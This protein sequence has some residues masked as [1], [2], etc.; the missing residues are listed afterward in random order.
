[1]SRG[2]DVNRPSSLLDN[3]E[4]SDIFAIIGRRSVSLS[5]T[6][7]QVFHCLPNQNHWQKKIVGVACFTKDNQKKSY[8]IRIV[9]LSKRIIVWEQE[10]YN[11]FK[12]N[13][14]RP[15]FH[16]FEADDC[17]AGLNFADANEAQHFK[18]VIEEKLR[19]K[20][21]RKNDRRQTMARRGTSSANTQGNVLQPINNNVNQRASPSPTISPSSSSNDLKKKGGKVKKKTRLTKD[22]IGTPSD[23]RHVGHVG[24]DPKGGFDV[25]NIDPQWKKLFDTIGVTAKQLQDEETSQFIYDFVESHGGIEKATKELE[26]ASPP[27]QAAPPPPPPPMHQRG[28]PRTAPP[29]PPSHLSGPPT[30]RHG[31]RPPIGAAPKAPPPAPPSSRNVPPP[32][33]PTGAPAPPPPPPPPTVGPVPP[34]PPPMNTGP[35]SSGPGR[36]GLL[37]QIH[38]GKQ[39][40]RVEVNDKPAGGDGRDDLLSAIRK[41]RQLK[42]V[43][44]SE[45]EQDHSSSSD[46]DGM[47]G[48]LAKALAQRSAHI[49][50]SDDDDDDDEDDDF[51]DDDWD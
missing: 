4:N 36:G 24:W 16:S 18:H 23:F 41:G 40:N 5:T 10:L 42:T 21:Q 39:L 12:Y 30:G 19:A 15:H 31:G 22:D 9:D 27:T 7:V 37:D 2:T 20:Q 46:L 32:P 45:I 3:G 28:I 50:V 43:S 48:A 35:P 33:P 13:A 44:Q 51:D 49:Q 26:K 38:Q 11:Q 17:I 14:P 47:A 25:D 34:P 8:F 6:V 29:P 1:M